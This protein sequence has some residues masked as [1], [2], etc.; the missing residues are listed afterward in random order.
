MAIE[1]DINYW[2]DRKIQFTCLKKL[3]NPKK[4]GI[5]RIFVLLF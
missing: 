5:M 1:M 2:F 3:R 4:Y